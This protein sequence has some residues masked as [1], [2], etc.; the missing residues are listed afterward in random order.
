MSDHCNIF[1]FHGM[2]TETKKK[3]T[4]KMFLLSILSI[5]LHLGFSLKMIYTSRQQ[6]ASP[7]SHV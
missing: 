5:R 7:C 1:F 4:Q 6:F 2:V 3:M